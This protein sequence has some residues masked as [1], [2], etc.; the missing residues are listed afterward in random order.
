MQQ[1]EK[2]LDSNK[3][4]LNMSKPKHLEFANEQERGG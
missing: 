1:V 3:M 4:K 2:C